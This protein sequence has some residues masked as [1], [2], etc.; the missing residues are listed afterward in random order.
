MDTFRHTVK[1]LDAA[2]RGM[3]PPDAPIK[4]QVDPTLR[5]VSLVRPAWIADGAEDPA[6]NTRAQYSVVFIAASGYAT[7]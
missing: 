1:T 6:G 7:S 5:A 3:P 2:L 4:V